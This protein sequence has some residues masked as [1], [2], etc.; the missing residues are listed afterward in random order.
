MIRVRDMNVLLHVPPAMWA[1]LFAVGR[2]SGDSA[3]QVQA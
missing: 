2:T 1:S 3:V